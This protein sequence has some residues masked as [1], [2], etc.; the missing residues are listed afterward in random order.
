M[1]I[2][3][4]FVLGYNNVKVLANREKIEKLNMLGKFNKGI[5]L[6]FVFKS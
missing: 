5:Y 4:K 2:V 1:S 6:N 3:T